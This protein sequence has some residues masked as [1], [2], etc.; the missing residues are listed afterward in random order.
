MMRVIH[1]S[2]LKV[3]LETIAKISRVQEIRVLMDFVMSL[4][5]DS[6]ALV[7]MAFPGSSARSPLA[8]L[9]LV[10]TKE[11]A[12]FRDLRLLA[13]VQRDSLDKPAT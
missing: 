3:L 5:M 4:E 8:P 11:S 7:M 9:I 1:A 10:D 13:I 6:N 12:L 2:V